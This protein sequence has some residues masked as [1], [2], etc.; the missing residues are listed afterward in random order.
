MTAH[1]PFPPVPPR[2]TDRDPSPGKDPRTHLRRVPGAA[3]GSCAEHR[4]AA[5]V[6]G[7]R[8]DDAAAR[9]RAAFGAGPDAAILAARDR[10]VGALDGCAADPVTLARLVATTLCGPDGE[11]RARPMA[12]AVV[13]AHRMQ[14]VVTAARGFGLALRRAVLTGQGTPACPS[15]GH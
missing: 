10:L 4:L 7:L 14:T 9:L 15:R 1:A 2:A 5:A 13:P 3:T 11:E 8:R 6:L 12:L